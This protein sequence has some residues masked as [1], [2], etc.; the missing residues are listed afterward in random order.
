MNANSALYLP[1]FGSSIRYTSEH[2]NWKVV[3]TISNSKGLIQTS[4]R[5]VGVFAVVLKQSSRFSV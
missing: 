2:L 5:S 3:N 1:S 4:E